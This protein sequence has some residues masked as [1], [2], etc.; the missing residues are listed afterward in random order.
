MYVFGNPVV[1]DGLGRAQ[2][3]SIHGWSP[4]FYDGTTWRRLAAELAAK[5]PAYVFADGF[6]ERFIRARAPG[7]WSWLGQRYAQEHSLPGG[8]AILRL[9]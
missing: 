5:P 4:E 7:L 9:R 2:R 3:I 8:I 6:S 1:L